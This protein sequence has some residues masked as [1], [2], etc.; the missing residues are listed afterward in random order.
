MSQIV[1]RGLASTKEYQLHVASDDLALTLLT[2]LRKNSLPIASSCSG[3]GVCKK[4]IINQDI[5]S[6]KKT[7]IEW[8]VENKI[9]EVGYL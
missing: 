1:V 3:E 4:C 2:F 9:I 8:L 7:V 5:L 6:C